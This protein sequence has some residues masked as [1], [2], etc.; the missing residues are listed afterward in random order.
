[1][2]MTPRPMR[3]APPSAPASPSGTWLW[4]A[5]L[6]RLYQHLFGR[7]IPVVRPCIAVLADGTSIRGALVVQSR[8]HIEIAGADVATSGHPFV[9]A[10]GKVL[11]FNENVSFIQLLG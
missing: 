10:D 8:T 1:M 5:A 2:T 6:T 3:L 11:V 9:H 4:W 7:P